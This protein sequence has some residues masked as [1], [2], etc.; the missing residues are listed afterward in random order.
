MILELTPQTEQNLLNLLYDG[1]IESIEKNGYLESIFNHLTQDS[2]DGCR[3]TFFHYAVETGD[4]KLIKYLIF[5]KCDV[6]L[7]D[8]FGNSAL[9]ITINKGYLE[10]VSQ[11]LE[12]GANP[13]IPDLLGRAPLHYLVLYY[14]P[15]IGS[16]EVVVPDI[17]ESY[18]ACIN[19]LLQ[20]GADISIEDK[21][22]FK[23]CDTK[24]PQ[25]LELLQNKRKIKE[26]KLSNSST[27]MFQKGPAD[28][29][30]ISSKQELKITPPPH[31]PLTMNKK[32]TIVFDI[33]DVLAAH[34]TL[35]EEVKLYLLR[36]S[37]LVLAADKEHQIFPGVIELMR[38]LYSKNNIN[39]AF[40]SSAVKERNT[41]FVK[42][43]LT[44][45]LGA[46]K[47]AE[48]EN[49]VIILSRQDL[50]SSDTIG[51]VNAN[52]MYK[53]YGLSS[54]NNK[55]DISKALLA[56]GLLKNAVFIDDDSSYIYYDQER[57]FLRCDGSS[58]NYAL[59]KQDPDEDKEIGKWRGEEYF[60]PYNKIFYLAAVLSMCLKIFEAGE[61][62]QEFLFN[63]QFQKSTENLFSYR[64]NSDVT[65]NKNYYL[66]GLELLQQ[67]NPGLSF[68]T[69]EDYAHILSSPITEKE[70][71]VIEEFKG[72][73][74]ASECSMM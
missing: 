64:L 48:I 54:G 73:E 42:K 61:S 39:V 46:E 28:S 15:N 24:N 26:T 10:N 16:D 19:M 34:Q 68:V 70:Q 13:N 6:N 72:K 59:L 33:D 20:F 31:A 36:K 66:Q 1:D 5:K 50:T 45:A 58:V 2:H 47:Y 71:N 74:S 65:K 18:R 57:N 44:I 17:S 32:L 29:I 12:A 37:A 49:T 4:S 38:F 62:V 40:F 14:N 9:H 7:Q 63:F 35:K 30:E 51:R 60:Y 53:Y 22:G 21:Y 3:K 43:L 55:K 56:D 27:F 11:L 23:P 69:S 41:E 25:M 8:E 67:V 52:L